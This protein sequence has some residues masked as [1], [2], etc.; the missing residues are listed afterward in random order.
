LYEGLAR[1]RWDYGWRAFLFLGRDLERRE[2]LNRIDF[3]DMG[4]SVM[5][6]YTSADIE[7]LDD[8]ESKPRVL[9]SERGYR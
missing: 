8:L 9:G 1:G 3:A 6:P 2:E 5:R 7:D 4:R